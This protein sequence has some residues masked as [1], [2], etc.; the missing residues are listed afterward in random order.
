MKKN[1]IKRETYLEKL[2]DYKDSDF[3]KVFT[4][5]R[6]SGKTSLLHSWA[7]ELEK[8]GINKNNI[9]FISFESPE[10]NS[11]DNNIDLDKIVYEKTKNLEGTI[12]LFF[13]EIQQVDKWEKSING[14]RVS[15]DCDIYISGS[16]S[17]L[18]SG[19]LA[20]ILAGRYINIRVYPFSFKEIIQYNN[21]IENIELTKESINQLFNEYYINYGGMPSILPF[22]SDESRKT[23]LADI[24][25]SILL[26]DIINRFNI[27]NID[28]LKRYIN[29]MMNSIGQT[30]SSK[31]V[32]NYLKSNDVYTT[33]N[34]LLKYNE[35][36]QQTFFIS[37]CSRY[38]FKGKKMMKIKEKYYLMDH[39]FHHALIEKNS[40]WRPRVIENIVYIELLRRGYKVNVGR[41]GEEKKDNDKNEIEI[42]FV[43]E[44]S[45]QYIY[46]QV[47]YTLF[48]EKTKE[49]EFKPFFKIP[50]KYDTYI[51]TTDTEDFSYKGVKHL[52]I[53]DFL[54]GDEI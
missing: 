5:I 6:R 28:L 30:F 29:F 16:N 49:R 47:S 42:D 41:L 53:I 37:K 39:G 54:L 12:Y 8:K 25:D 35:Y 31:K 9:I 21:E 1:E 36:L 27:K 3:V 14:Y 38:D 22:K 19:E 15:L 40:V 45:G 11:I 50:D 4:G 23:A 44:K 2:E 48:S 24:Y 17:K 7:E 52:N 13:D 51:I 46:V 26:N 34:T 10:Y 32:K 43:C 18:L 33:Q 20:S